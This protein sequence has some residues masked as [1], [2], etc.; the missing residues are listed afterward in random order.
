MY[1]ALLTFS[2]ALW[3]NFA[4]FVS[5]ATNYQA[6]KNHKTYCD[7][8]AALCLNFLETACFVRCFKNVTLCEPHIG[9]D[10]GSQGKKACHSSPGFA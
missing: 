9:T 10:K 1:M 5:M 2:K 7:H 4:L 3:Y 6:E 8:H